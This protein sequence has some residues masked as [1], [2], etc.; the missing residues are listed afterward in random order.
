M[1]IINIVGRKPRVSGSDGHFMTTAGKRSPILPN[2][3]KSETGNFMHEN[4]FNRAVEKYY[5]EELRRCGFDYLSVALDDY[6]TPLPVRD[7]RSD[8]FNADFHLDIHANAYDSDFDPDGGTG[9]ETFYYGNGTV[10]SKQCADVI[11]RHLMNDL[12][13]DMKSR[14]IKD[15]SHLYMLNA[16]NAVANLTELGFMDN[17]H[18][19]AFLLSDSY[20]KRCAVALAKATCE[21]FGKPYIPVQ[22][23]TPA[24][25]VQP[26]TPQGIGLLVIVE[27]TVIRK[28]A[29]SESGIIRPIGT[30]EGEFIVWEYRNGWYNIGGWVYKQHIRFTP[31]DF[32]KMNK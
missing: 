4:E 9:I 6:D 17:L 3:M 25:T 10:K 20:R 14:G 7:K 13:G 23:P 24:V 16:T 28:D 2:G 30:S 29:T 22:Q 18:D 5:G 32:V 21:I 1:T 27:G 11:Q 15:G 8:D 26:T 12:G 19:I 31:H